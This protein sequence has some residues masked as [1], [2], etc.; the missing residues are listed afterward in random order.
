MSSRNWNAEVPL[1]VS[2]KVEAFKRGM[3]DFVT[4]REDK[5]HE[6]QDAALRVLVDNEHS[7]FLYG[8]A[9][10]GAKSWTGATWELFMALAYPETRYFVGRAVLKRLMESTLP[11]FYKV[12]KAYE[13]PDTLY[14]FN[15]GYNY[16]QF[17]NGSRIDF[18]ALEKKPSD[19]FFETLGSIEY[20][21]G[22]IEEAGEVCFDAYDTLRTRINRQMND[23]YGI[24]GKLFITCNPK[25]NWMFRIF[26]EPWK[27]GVLDDKKCYMPCLVQENPFIESGYIEKLRE[28][29]DKVKKERLLKGNWDYEDNPNALCQYDDICAIFGNK[30]AVQ[31]GQYYLTADI[32][33][34]GSDK[35]RI[36]VWNGYT[37]VDLC[38]FDTSSTTE[39][40]QCILHF[41]RLYHIPSSRCI[42]D[43]DGVGGGVI[44]HT[45]CVGFRNNGTPLIEPTEYT[46]EN[47]MNLQT[48]CGYRLADHINNHDV[49]F[50]PTLVSEED[51][52]QIVM[53][54]EQLQTWNGDS[55]GR[56]QLKPKAEIKEDIGHSPDWRD[57]MLMRCYFDYTDLAVPKDIEKR[58]SNL[59]L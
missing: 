48:Q 56:L 47:F 46:A 34:F 27:K 2:V 50:V 53:E 10:G 5:K 33:R 54:I 26:Y 52:E 38:S 23:A 14:H 16:F 24:Y 1:D 20:T 4:V 43:E 58:L 13:I 45:G 41:Q 40:E 39:I 32:A 29:G 11:T 42:A 36:L 6:K 59:I 28:I 55:D 12:M 3:F 15:G 17:Y 30:I 22:W 31:N 18:V 21:S 51:L 7:E 25:K 8:G 9:A 49:G 19:P 35:A 44:D 37:V 57:A